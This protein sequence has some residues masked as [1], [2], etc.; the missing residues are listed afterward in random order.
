MQIVE[1][2]VAPLAHCLAQRAGARRTTQHAPHSSTSTLLNHERKSIE[3]NPQL[4]IFPSFATLRNAA[5]I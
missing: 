4:I 3:R 5:R 2:L 1:P